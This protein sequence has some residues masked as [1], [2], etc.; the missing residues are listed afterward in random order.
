L[1]E[2]VAARVADGLSTT[3]VGEWRPDVFQVLPDGQVVEERSP[4][5]EDTMRDLGE[6]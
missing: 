3:L 6:L 5:L 4:S 1:D 2:A